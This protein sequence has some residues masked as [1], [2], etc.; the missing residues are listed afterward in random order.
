MSHSF[1]AVFINTILTHTTT[2]NNYKWK[3]IYLKR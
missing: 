1:I 3:E 2:L